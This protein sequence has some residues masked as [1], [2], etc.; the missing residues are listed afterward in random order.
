MQRTREIVGHIQLEHVTLRVEATEWD[1]DE[2]DY[3]TPPSG[4]DLEI[5]GVFV[6]RVDGRQ[7][8]DSERARYNDWCRSLSDDAVL[9]RLQETY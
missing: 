7:P 8:T 1:F 2:G 4:G 5:T 9:K 6:E 3:W